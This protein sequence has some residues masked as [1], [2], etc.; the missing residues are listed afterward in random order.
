MDQLRENIDAV[1]V[2][3]SMELLTEIDAVHNQYPDPAP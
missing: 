2:E 1:E 3:L